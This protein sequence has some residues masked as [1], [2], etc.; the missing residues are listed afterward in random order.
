MAKA[1]DSSG[2]VKSRIILAILGA[3]LLFVTIVFEGRR[4]FLWLSER[5]SYRYSGE[6]SV[7]P[8]QDTVQHDSESVAVDSA[9]VRYR[10]KGIESGYVIIW[11]DSLRLVEQDRTTLIELSEVTYHGVYNAAAVDVSGE[12][13]E[14][15]FFV[16]KDGGTG[17]D[18][19]VI[20]LFNPRIQEVIEVSLMDSKDAADPIVDTVWSPNSTSS[21]LKAE[22]EYLERI[23][24]NYG[25]E[26][27]IPESDSA[28]PSLAPYFWRKDNGDKTEGILKIRRYPGTS[29]YG[30]VATEPNDIRIEPYVIGSQFKGSVIAHDTQRNEDFIIY[31]PTMIWHW[32]EPEALKTFRRILVIGTRGDGLVIVHMDSFRFKRFPLE[33]ELGI[34]VTIDVVGDSIVVNNRTKVELPRW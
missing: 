17:I 23:K 19:D 16:R 8:E 27:S 32:V 28:R 11:R 5:G 26:A 29:L 9:V 6:S 7:V 21:L 31:R 3:G 24:F 1:S 2:K 12:G 22:R 10:R 4:L 18:I 33:G 15:I 14:D 30:E 25:F 34:I 13:D 20:A